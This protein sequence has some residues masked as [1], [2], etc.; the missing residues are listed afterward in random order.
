M[1]KVDMKL[2]L[3]KVLEVMNKKTN[4]DY[5]EQFDRNLQIFIDRVAYGVSR[6]ELA[7]EHNLSACRIQGIEARMMR[8][9]QEIVK[10]MKLA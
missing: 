6:S 1:K 4:R 5:R 9:F 3:Q 2:D 7:R 8:Q 10:K